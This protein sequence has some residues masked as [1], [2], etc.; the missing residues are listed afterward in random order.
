[1]K[2]LFSLLLCLAMLATMLVSCAKDEGIITKADRPNLT[3]KIAIV[4]DDNTTEEGI[5][6]M[7][8]AFNAKA[9]VDLATKLEFV[10]FKASEYETKMREEMQRLSGAGALGGSA[11]ASGAAVDEDGYPVASDTQ[12]DLVLITGE[13]MYKEYA[14]NGWIINLDS[15]LSGTYKKLNTMVIDRAMAYVRAADP[16]PAENSAG[17]CYAIPAATTYGDY[18]YL[19]I[20]EAALTKYNIPVK[21]NADFAFAYE[22]FGRI[23][24]EPAPNNMQFWYNKY[25]SEGKTF[26]PVYNTPESFKLPGTI[27]LSHNGG[28]SL[29]GT[30]ITAGMI[31]NDY[32]DKKL[33][34]ASLTSMNLLDE[35]QY[36][37][38]L[39]LNFEA[40]KNHYFGTEQEEEFI[41]GIVKGDYSLRENEGYHYIVLENPVMQKS[42]V[43]DTM[44]AVSTFSVDKNRS[45]EILQELMTDDTGNGLLNIAFYG[46]ETE[47]YYLEDGVVRLRNSYSYAAHPDYLFGNVAGISYP[48]VNYGQTANAYSGYA[49][50]HKDLSNAF[51]IEDLYNESYYAFDVPAEWKDWKVGDPYPEGYTDI[52]ESVILNL[53]WA[54][55]DAY[56]L[57]VYNDLLASSDIDAFMEKLNDYCAK[58]N[59]ASST[60]DE[61][62]NFLEIRGSDYGQA[63]GNLTTVAGAFA[64]YI[65][66]VVN[67]RK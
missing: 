32:S 48:C 62:K 36:K 22:V 2:K 57:A 56:S 10:C 49:N 40:T 47:N 41:V 12:F 6:A 65:Y 27:Y 39:A 44:L 53:K 18:T 30:H 67:L 3:L 14:S 54:K 31:A 20:N 34:S 5:A 16:N 17:A 1:M 13:D 11:D 42:E 45:V 23:L 15:H 64:D 37:S 28:F 55:A 46:L 59:D 61:V 33:S 8:S 7:Q 35:V 9:S 4:V 58:M 21:A 51:I 24:S 63:G 43:F 29:L 52:P 25:D 26:A 38:Y 60:D 19:A 66:T 50:Q